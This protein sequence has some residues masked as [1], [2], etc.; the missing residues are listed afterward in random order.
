MNGI[1][2]FYCDRLYTPYGV[3]VKEE[4]RHEYDSTILRE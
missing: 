1:N 3:R 4:E 2:I